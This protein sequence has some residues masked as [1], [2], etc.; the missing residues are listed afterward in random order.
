MNLSI[1]TKSTALFV[2][3]LLA[4]TAVYAMF[5]VRL[6]QRECH[7]VVDRLQQ[8]ANLLAAEIDT[9]LRSERHR[10]EMV[11]RLPGL[12]FGLESIARSTTS[13]EIPAWTTLHYLFFKS[14]LFTQGVFLLD[15]SGNVIWN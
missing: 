8:T 14:Q 2:A 4:L 5:S 10:I 15:R 1:K 6:L 3:Y 11:S 12:A 7:S 9:S 13:G